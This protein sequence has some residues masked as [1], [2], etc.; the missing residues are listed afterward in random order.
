M[1]R[2]DEILSNFL[3]HEILKK[4]YHLKPKDLPTTIREALKSDVPIVKAIALIV[5]GLEAIPRIT[6]PTLRNQILQYLNESAI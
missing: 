6:D 1:A 5:D 4:N 2:K 3:R